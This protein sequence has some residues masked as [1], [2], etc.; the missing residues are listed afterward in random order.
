MRNTPISLLKGTRALIFDAEAEARRRVVGFLF[1]L[2]FAT[3][4][5]VMSVIN[6]G[7]NFVLGVVEAGFSILKQATIVVLGDPMGPL[8]VTLGV[9][10]TTEEDEASA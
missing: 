2:K 8:E 5:V 7:F 9:E 4:G 1:A 10:E 3:T 6:A